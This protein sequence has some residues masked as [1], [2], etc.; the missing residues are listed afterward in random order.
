VIPAITLLRQ[1]SMM[2]NPPDQWIMAAL[3][4][5][6][7]DAGDKSLRAISV[8]GYVGS[9]KAWDRFEAEWGVVL[10][11]HEIPY[12]HMAEILDPKSPMHKFCGKANEAAQ[13]ALLRDLAMALA[14]SSSAGRFVGIGGLVLLDALDRF[15]SERGRG[16]E[17]MPLALFTCL[18][19]M[20]SLF[21]AQTI[22]GLFDQVAQAE[23]QIAIAQGYLA[24]SPKAGG[25]DLA[26]IKPAKGDIN[27]KTVRGLQAADF[28]AYE[29]YNT[30]LQKYRLVMAGF[31][32][33][34][35]VFSPTFSTQGKKR[36]KSM[37]A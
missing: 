35:H 25:K 27:S 13:A 11:R 17:P 5:Y 20:Q 8:A 2:F 31:M 3:K 22:E 37:G 23:K 34:I 28:A 4:T 30:N 6:L 36:I 7:D 32:P 14:R 15:N 12:F 10:D 9:L 16:V 26:A 18:A 19:L 1:L 29:T 21:P 33:A 24:T